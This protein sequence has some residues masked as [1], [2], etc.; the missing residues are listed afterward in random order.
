MIVA[1]IDVGKASLDVSVAEGP[2]NRF[3]NTVE[4]ISKLL[5]HLAEQGAIVAVCEATGGYERLVVDR[6][7]ETGI[8]MQLAQPTRVRAFARACGYQAKTAPR[9]AQVLSRF[10]SV[11]REYNAG[12]PTL[13]PELEELRDLLRRR[14]QLVEQ[15][16]QELARVDKVVSPAVAESTFASR[17]KHFRVVRRF[18]VRTFK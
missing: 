11:F 16:V 5:K 17:R 2:V 12:A 7:R 3:D 15:R 14:R 10:G 6:L 9:D 18:S 4:G 13:E 1:G 8:H